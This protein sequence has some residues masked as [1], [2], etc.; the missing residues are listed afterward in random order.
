MGN[1]EAHGLFP[2]NLDLG[3]FQEGGRFEKK[4]C[5]L[6]FTEIKACLLPQ[7]RAHSNPIYDPT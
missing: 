6:M 5:H 4:G 1:F 2:E 7:E 3:A